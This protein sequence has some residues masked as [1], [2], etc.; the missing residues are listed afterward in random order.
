MNRPRR[1]QLAVHQIAYAVQIQ[2]DARAARAAAGQKEGARVFEA[3][4]HQVPDNLLDD[5][6][7]HERE[8]R[9]RGPGA[10]PAVARAIRHETAKTTKRRRCVKR[11]IRRIDRSI[12][13][14]TIL[15]RD[16]R[17]TR[18]DSPRDSPRAVRPLKESRTFSFRCDSAINY[19]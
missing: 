7:P 4:G 12:A 11:K 9:G 13:L 10:A 6:C 5:L 15:T 2:H 16:S 14:P 8:H 17:S 18:M 3:E 19:V 1:T